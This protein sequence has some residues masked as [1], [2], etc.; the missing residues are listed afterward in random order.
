MTAYEILHYSMVNDTDDNKVADIADSIKENGW[1]GMPI[2][3]SEP[4]GILITG[5]HRLAA[6][7]SLE[8]ELFLDDLG[9]VAEDVTDLIE[10][11]CEETGSTM[12]DIQYDN[13]SSVFAGTWVEEYKDEMIEW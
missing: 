7:K 3:V 13:L 10:S 1:V 11:W 4:Y 2:L 9:D 8:D 12:D 5:S 6:L